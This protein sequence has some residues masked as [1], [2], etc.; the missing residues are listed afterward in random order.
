[1]LEDAAFLHEDYHDEV[2]HGRHMIPAYDFR[3]HT[4]ADHPRCWCNPEYH[5]DSNTYVHNSYD[6]REDY[7][8][9]RRLPH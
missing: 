1:M 6:G 8:E 3:K 5:E 7:E 2:V 9:G 4:A